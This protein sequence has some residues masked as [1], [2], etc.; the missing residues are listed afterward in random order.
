MTL[1]ELHTLQDRINFLDAFLHS[2]HLCVVS[3]VLAYQLDIAEQELAYYKEV[4]SEY[5]SK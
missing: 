5:I 4:V 3:P 1:T 2:Y